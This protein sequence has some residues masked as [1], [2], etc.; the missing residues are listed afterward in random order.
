M[1][2]HPTEAALAL[3]AG[4]DLGLLD[5]LRI[6]L[7]VR[8]C[9]ACA[10]RLAALADARRQLRASALELPEG[11]DWSRLAGEMRANI[12]VGLAAGA[13]VGGPA[14]RPS[15][16]ASSFRLAVVLASLSFVAVAGWLLR[17]PQPSAP[18]LAAAPAV[19]LEARPDGLALRGHDA[20]LTLLKPASQT[21]AT[22]TVSWDGSARSSFVDSE[23]GQVTIYNVSAQ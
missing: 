7:H 17:A 3:H 10:A 2:L 14:S 21:A 12:R 4:G 23:T 11:L 18:D 9:P 15:P 16:D 19:L 8:G 22:T 5:R 13:I 20:A 6:H 1:K